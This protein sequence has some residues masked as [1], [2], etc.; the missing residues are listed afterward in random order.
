MNLID[1]VPVTITVNGIEGTEDAMTLAE[2]YDEY[3]ATLEAEG[4]G[5]PSSSCP[6][7]HRGGMVTNG[8]CRC[9][10]NHARSEVE[11]AARESKLRQ[12][13][14]AGTRLARAVRQELTST[15]RKA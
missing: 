15:G 1:K 8:P 13:A 6:W 7:W 5:C 10:T 2:A 9:G 14:Y 12:A 11:R 4:L 3:A